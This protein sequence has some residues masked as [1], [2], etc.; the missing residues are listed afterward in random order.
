M[1]ASDVEELSVLE[2]E[3]ESMHARG[4]VYGK[5]GASGIYVL[6][7]KSL[8]EADTKRKLNACKQQLT[9]Q[10]PDKQ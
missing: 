4:R 6:K 7:D 1:K 2:G 5:L 10:T 8:V 3:L 9:K